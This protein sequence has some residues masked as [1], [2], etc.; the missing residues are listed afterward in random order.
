MYSRRCK[1]HLLLF[2]QLESQFF[3]YSQ[4]LSTCSANAIARDF[5]LKVRRDAA[6]GELPMETKDT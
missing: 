2:A 5:I 1:C 4:T 6:S 3:L